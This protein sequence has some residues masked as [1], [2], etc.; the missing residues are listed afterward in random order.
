[1]R[2]G[3]PVLKAAQAGEQRHHARLAEAQAG[4]DSVIFD[5]WQHHAV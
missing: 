4:G 1:V 2:L 3:E 5:R